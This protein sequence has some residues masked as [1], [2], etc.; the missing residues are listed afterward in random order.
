MQYEPDATCG[1]TRREPLECRNSR[2]QMPYSAPVTRG[3]TLTAGGRSPESS[4]RMSSNPRA[5][6]AVALAAVCGAALAAG[7]AHAAPAGDATAARSAACPSAAPRR[8]RP[9]AAAGRRQRGH[10]TLADGVYRVT[11]CDRDG[12]LDVVY[13]RRARRDPDGRRCW[14]PQRSSRGG[15]LLTLDYGDPRDPRWAKAWRRVRARVAPRRDGGDPRHAAPDPAFEPPQ[16]DGCPRARRRGDGIRRAGRAA[17]PPRRRATT[18]D[19]SRAARSGPATATGGGGGRSTFG[20]QQ[21]HPPR[22]GARRAGLGPDQRT[23][24]TSATSPTITPSVRRR[25]RRP[26]RERR[27]TSAPSTR[28]TWRR[29]AAKARWR[30]RRSGVHAHRG[31]RGRHPLQRPR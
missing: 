22:G 27:T 28:A 7:P 31:R 4:P 20:S 24:A 10:R 14:R 29:S 5:R 15:R 30:A 26:R 2:T 18:A 8:R 13:D 3:S 17:A 23:A 25:D 12:T 11:R 1:G 6:G 16:R 19:T 21:R 9:S